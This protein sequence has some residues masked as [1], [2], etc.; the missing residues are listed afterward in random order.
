MLLSLLHILAETRLHH[1]HRPTYMSHKHTKL[2]RQ[3]MLCGCM[4]QF[5]E[6][7]CRKAKIFMLCE[8]LDRHC[9]TG[10]CAKEPD[11]HPLSSLDPVGYNL[12][13]H[14]GDALYDLN[15][16]IDD[17]DDIPAGSSKPDDMPPR[18]PFSVHTFQAR[19]PAFHCSM[20]PPRNSTRWQRLP[21]GTEGEYQ[22]QLSTG[23]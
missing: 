16:S 13:A 22:K 8:L 7:P 18:S 23:P 21:C 6:V 14:G 5:A 1:E 10:S 4:L 19:Y 2:S 17:N 3:V 11:I 12:A 9:Q 20:L 15:D